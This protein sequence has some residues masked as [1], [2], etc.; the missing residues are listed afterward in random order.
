MSHAREA[1]ESVASLLE[2]GVSPHQ[3]AGIGFNMATWYGTIDSLRNTD[4][5]GSIL[6]DH[7]DSCGTVACISGHIAMKL[8][9]ATGIKLYAN[10]LFEKVWPDGEVSP[11]RPS[12]LSSDYND[13]QDVLYDLFQPNWHL[14]WVDLNTITA[15]QAAKA[16]RNYLEIGY[17]AWSTILSKEDNALIEFKY[18]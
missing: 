2:S 15:A 12:I 14:S 11:I 1:F 6:T 4:G 9:R 13:V 16:I 3:D 18:L 17:P 10:D 5:V 8:G 7:T